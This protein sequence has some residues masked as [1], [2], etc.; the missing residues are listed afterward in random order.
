VVKRK[1]EIGWKACN[2]ATMQTVRTIQRLTTTFT[3]ADFEGVSYTV[4]TEDDDF[5]PEWAFNSP[6]GASFWIVKLIL[7]QH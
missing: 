2:Q 5:A 4:Q 3:F 1:W 6:A 7:Y